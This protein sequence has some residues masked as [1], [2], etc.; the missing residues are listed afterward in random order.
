[1]LGD[2]RGREVDV[3]KNAQRERETEREQEL[4]ECGFAREQNKIRK[5]KV[6]KKLKQ[7]CATEA[8][9]CTALFNRVV[10]SNTIY[11]SRFDKKKTTLSLQICVDKDKKPEKT[12]ET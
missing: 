4:K 2:K 6:E 9:C 3:P 1:M 5:R 7:L 12:N 11:Y 8:I 10:V